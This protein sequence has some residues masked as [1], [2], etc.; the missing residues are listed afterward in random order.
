MEL[1]QGSKTSGWLVVRSRDGGI[2]RSPRRKGWALFIWGHP[3]VTPT[4]KLLAVEFGST[5][6]EA[7]QKLPRLLAYGTTPSLPLLVS[8][9]TAPCTVL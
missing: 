3:F 2:N 6:Q 5:P 4:S 7:G 8:A 1:L 9:P